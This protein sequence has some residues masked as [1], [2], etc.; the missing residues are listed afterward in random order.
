MEI[1]KQDN[2]KNNFS[3]LDTDQ[4]DK[5]FGLSYYDLTGLLLT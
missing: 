2:Y 3:T 1:S 5:T 4:I